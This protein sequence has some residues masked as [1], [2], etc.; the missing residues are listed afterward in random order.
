MLLLCVAVLDILR[1]CVRPSK[2]LARNRSMKKQ[3]DYGFTPGQEGGRGGGGSGR[4]QTVDVLWW[5]SSGLWYF[6][7]VDS[8]L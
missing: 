5:P 3:L 8:G 6:I 1:V 2:Y 4:G 7:V